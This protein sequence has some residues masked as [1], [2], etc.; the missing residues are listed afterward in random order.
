[1]CYTKDKV[2]A[3]VTNPVVD[4]THPARN[5]RFPGYIL[6]KGPRMAAVL[7]EMVCR[8]H[9]PPRRCQNSVALSYLVP[10]QDSHA[11]RHEHTLYSWMYPR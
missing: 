9:S 11:R 5:K 6:R 8:Y 4:N 2:K 10:F 7:K 1:M 3:A